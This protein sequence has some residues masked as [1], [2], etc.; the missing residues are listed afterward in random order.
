M[1]LEKT[2]RLSEFK[3]VELRAETFN[4]FEHAQF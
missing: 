1:A 3:S 2:L 4:V